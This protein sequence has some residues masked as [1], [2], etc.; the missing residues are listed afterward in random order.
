MKYSVLF[1]CFPQIGK[2]FK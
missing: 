2:I 1:V